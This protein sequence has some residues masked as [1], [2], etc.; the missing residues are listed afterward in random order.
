MDSRLFYSYDIC[1]LLRAAARCALHERAPS[2]AKAET[3]YRA[4]CTWS[5]GTMPLPVSSAICAVLC[6]HACAE[7]VYGGVAV[8][9]L[10]SLIDYLVRL[11]LPGLDVGSV[12]DAQRAASVDQG[13]Y[14][15][16]KPC[17]GTDEHRR[18]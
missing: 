1:R 16:V 6:M 11:L 3:T 7:T 9:S 14:R 15:V 13:A 12:A 10:G 18:G 2:K 8:L 5:Y 17:M 4:F